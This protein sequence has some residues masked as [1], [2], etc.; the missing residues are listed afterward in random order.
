MWAKRHGPRWWSL[1]SGALLGCSGA[2]P[3][4]PFVERD[5]TSDAGADAPDGDARDVSRPPFDAG[6]D[7][8]PNLGG[9]C[10]DDGQCDDGVECT[11]DRCDTEL[12]RCRN[13]PDD[14]PCADS[15]YCDG[16]EV[17]DRRLGCREGEPLTCSD[18]FVCTIDA[19]VEETRSCTHA[20]RDADGDGDPLWNCKGGTDCNDA[21]PR[22]S[23]QAPEICEN[24]VDDDCDL[25]IDE[26]EGCESSDHDTCVEPLL[27][28]ASGRYLVSTAG[29]RADYAASCAGSG[30]AWR[31]VV[32]AIT[33]P[34]GP[35]LDVDVTATAAS[36]A[37]ALAAARQCGDASSEL[38]CQGADA[39][40]S[41]GGVARLLLRGLPPGTYPL[42]VFASSGLSIALDVELGPVTP[43][44]ANETCGTAAPLT[45][46]VHVQ[47]PLIDAARD[48]ETECT[49]Q[50]GELV[51]RFVLREPRDVHLHAASLD[52]R[53]HP[54][55]SLRDTRCSALAGE[56]FC[57]SA[58]ASY[59]FARALPAGRH[60][61]AVSATAATEVDLV[62]ELA[63]P[64]TPP[65]DENCESA[66]VLE[67]NRTIDVPLVDHVDDLKLGCL[68]GARDAAY[69]L[70]LGARSDVL[71]VQRISRGDTGGVS[72]A[73][74]PCAS[75]SDLLACGVSSTSPVRKA[76]RNASPGS[77]RVIGETTVGGATELGA[78]VRP[79]TPP[80]FVALADDCASALA[81]PET[82]GVFQGNTANASAGSS[83]GCDGNVDEPEGAPDQFLV[84]DLSAPRRVI[85]DMQGSEF[86]TLL[87]VRR[88]PSCP[89]EEI[90]LACSAGY[91]S[92]RSY[93]D[94]SLPAG[95]YFVQVDGYS[96]ASGAWS[97]DVFVVEP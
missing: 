88:G 29:A 12:E 72:L 86:Q 13:V 26:A 48:L 65:A 75:A 24:S 56:L 90:P 11:V 31:D 33:V 78:F 10:L 44:P 8:D 82:G 80:V 51:Y 46:G 25:E 95:R 50:T 94:L 18:E 40:A 92:D 63:P 20:V 45:P 81:I 67:H 74:A 5:A 84:L 9:P 35:P 39:A 37:F 47:V 93:L 23:G 3:P 73:R 30:G 87:N 52:G 49:R 83:A 21:D 6:A 19:C 97:L 54:S 69:A 58:A 14:R 1:L 15:V 34:E 4:S 2:S 41:G 85:L 79:S 66:P 62:L 96:G 70:E 32:V 28:T 91:T 89:G 59:V 16:V 77:Y 60:Y 38:G 64:T 17:C 36:V 57:Q 55:L 27:V 71:L 68:L 43:P 22:I 53:G 42:Y 76:I 61:V 7:A